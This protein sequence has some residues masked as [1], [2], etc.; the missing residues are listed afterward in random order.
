MTTPQN[1]ATDTVLAAGPI[2]GT[3]GV[4]GLTLCTGLVLVLG[5]RGAKR[6]K[7]DRDKSGGLGIVFG[8][9]AVAAGGLWSD[10]AKG[11]SEI[12][13]SVVQG[14]IFGDIGLGAVALSLSALTF[15]PDWKKTVAP[16][17]LGI[18]AG[19]TYGMAG[20]LW[21]LCSMFVLK[22]GAS[23]GAM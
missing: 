21:G 5:W 10:L 6:V 7:M 13:A 14:G 9:L 16:G 23:L 8:T 19:V 15:L 11:V 18:S 17:L 3:V 4:S 12:P 22:I 20:G 1:I 2:L